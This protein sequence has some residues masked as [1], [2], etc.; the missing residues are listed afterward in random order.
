MSRRWVASAFGAALALGGCNGEHVI[1]SLDLAP[2][3]DP[4]SVEG[5][6]GTGC[7][8]T[9]QIGLGEGH[10]CALLV[11]RTVQCWGLNE[12]GQLGIG[13]LEGKRDRPSLVPGLAAVEQLAL[14][15]SHTCA[16]IADGSVEC[17]GLSLQ[18]SPSLIRG[19]SN[20]IR[21]AV[22]DQSLGTGIL[23]TALLD[24]GTLR[25]VR[26]DADSTVPVIE[27]PGYRN[28]AGIGSQGKYLIMRSGEVRLATDGLPV[29]GFPSDVM[30]IVEDDSHSCAL[31]ARGSVL[32]WGLNPSGQLGDGTTDDRVQPAQVLGLP[33][34]DQISVGPHHSCARSSDGNGYCWGAVWD[35]SQDGSS[36][37]H[38]PHR[39]PGFSS[40]KQLAAGKYHTCGVEDDGRTACFGLNYLGQ[41]G[42]GTTLQRSAPTR[43]DW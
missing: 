34:V 7:P 39:I 42:L 24:D 4:G 15:T 32:C 23:L 37:Y 36:E 29:S 16:R 5:C 25:R 26:V 6:A 10:T 21:I 3:L 8:N 40:V 43:V 13:T 38:G 35:A 20:V 19:L 31:T 17:W 9:R 27:D 11:D 41:L 18:N 1:G 30:A 28:V 14:G 33:A 22:D 2:P 12:A